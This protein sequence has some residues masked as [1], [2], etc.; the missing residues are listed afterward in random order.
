MISE[1][2]KILEEVKVKEV[3]LKNYF[4]F[5]NIKERKEI[6]KYFSKL[7]NKKIIHINST[8]EGGGVAQILHS[9]VPLLKNGKANCSWYK[10][11]AK[12]E[13]FE[14]T[15]KIHNIIQGDGEKLTKKEE[16][17]YLETS[18]KLAE[19]LKKKKFDLLVIHDPQPLGALIF[20]NFDPIILRFHLD[21]SRFKKE[22]VP[23]LFA[24][25][26]NANKVVFSSRALVIKKITPEIKIIPP[27]IDPFSD[28]NKKLSISSSKKIIKK[29]GLS[30]ENPIISQVSR[31]DKFKNPEG[32]I[33]IYK[34]LK[35]EIPKLQLIIF[36]LNKAQ[37]DP[38]AEEIFKLVEKKVGK[39]KD[40]HL[41]LNPKLIENISFSEKEIVNAIQTNSDVVLQNSYREAF[42]LTV[43]EAMWKG[44]PVV[45]GVGKGIQQQIIDGKT[46]YII[47]SKKEAVEK[48]LY[49]LKSKKEAQKIGRKGKESVR[50]NY[51]MTRLLKDHLSLY[52]ELLK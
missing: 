15:K 8:S 6:E 1:K 32:V 50:K 7:Q 5:I 26:N 14:V 31:F 52:T 37:D 49:L 18:K 25:I 17:I 20:A 16:E 19:E 12:K 45:G 2:E 40:I 21:T 22:N 36:G 28:T 9:L 51:L 23:F 44:T 29:L 41:F 38:E 27:A 24:A 11:R 13:F 3:K 33:D 10:M 35:K 39:E 47:K 42:G 48:I 43:T 4:P 30:L 34:E 46:G